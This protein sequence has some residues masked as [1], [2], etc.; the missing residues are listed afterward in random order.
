MAVLR[1]PVALSTNKCESLDSEC[2]VYE[3]RNYISSWIAASEGL[4]YCRF[5]PVAADLEWILFL[6]IHL[7]RRAIT[8][9]WP[10]VLLIYI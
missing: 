1:R 9:C 6:I 7:V 2:S 5:A 8:E 4:N 10:N 3:R